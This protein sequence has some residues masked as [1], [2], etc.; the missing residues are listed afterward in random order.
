MFRN[1][2]INVIFL[3]LQVWSTKKHVCLF[4][5]KSAL[6]SRHQSVGSYPGKNVQRKNTK[7]ARLSLPRIA[8]KY[9][10]ANHAQY[11]FLDL[12]PEPSRIGNDYDSHHFTL[13]F[14]L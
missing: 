1:L 10:S 2:I 6:R 4:Q 11:A 12:L 8:K 13:L 9:A 3:L 5:L 7:F 14:Y